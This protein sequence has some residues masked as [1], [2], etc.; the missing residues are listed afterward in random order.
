MENQ[1]RTPSARALNP[2]AQQR[3]HI[4]LA[5]FEILAADRDFVRPGQIEE[6]RHI[7]CKIGCAVR[8]RDTQLESRIRATQTLSNS[9]KP[10]MKVDVTAPIPGISTPSFP[11]A[12]AMTFLLHRSRVPCGP[13][14][15]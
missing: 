13:T 15:Y 2:G 3:F 14:L 7:G 1:P 11:S 5:G 4:S 10:A 8:K 12:G 6:R 9:L